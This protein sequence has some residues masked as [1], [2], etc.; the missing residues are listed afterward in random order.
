MSERPAL[1]GR[2]GY[3]ACDDDADALG[4][5]ERPVDEGTGISIRTEEGPAGRRGLPFV[6][7]AAAGTASSSPD[8]GA[9][10]CF[11]F[12]REKMWLRSSMTE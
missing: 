4:R 10:G 5:G 1:A 6:Y 2:E 9:G 12:L 8:G 3:G 11:F 7:S